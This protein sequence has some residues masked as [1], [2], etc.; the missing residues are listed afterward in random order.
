[1]FCANSPCETAYYIDGSMLKI[2]SKAK[3]ARKT[4]AKG[5]TKLIRI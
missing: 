1:M 5:T 2:E 4:F 3:H